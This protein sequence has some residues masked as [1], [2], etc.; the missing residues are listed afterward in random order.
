MEK[1]SI[2]HIMM[3]S[4]ISYQMLQTMFYHLSI[5]RKSHLLVSIYLYVG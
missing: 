3:H 4:N 1:K 5:L 2:R